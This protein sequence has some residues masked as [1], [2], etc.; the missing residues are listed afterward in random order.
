MREDISGVMKNRLIVTLSEV[1]V[2]NLLRMT[3]FDSAHPD[4]ECRV[5]LSE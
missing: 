4:G 2:C 3:G 1:E 5:T